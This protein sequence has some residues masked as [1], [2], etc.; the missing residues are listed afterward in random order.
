M[1][2]LLTGGC[3][4]LGRSIRRVGAGDHEFVVFDVAE[5]AAAEGGVC[6]SITD[7]A[8]VY[9]AAEGCDA[10]IHTAAM[11]GTSLGTQSNAEFIRTNVIGAE[12]L[13]QAALKFDIRR[14]VMSSTLEVLCGRDWQ[15][16]GTAVYDEAL[17]PRPDWIY[18]LTKVQV[19]QLGSFYA[20]EYGLE[21]AQLR[22]SYVQDEPLEVLG[23]HLLARNVM[24]TDAARANL[25][26]ATVAGLR[27]EVF[28][29]ACDT[30]LTQRDVNDARVDPWVVLERHWP[31]C[32]PVLEQH[33]RTPRY[34]HFWPVSRIDKAKLMLGWQP[35]SRFDNYLRHLGWSP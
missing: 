27:E 11:H 31:G 23:M 24:A 10:I 32:R 18:P 19:E 13:F 5:E 22:Y 8:A 26:A 14:L 16:Y 1:R 20:R 2:I 12:H 15:A 4:M 34:E 3:G 17:P 29:I 25:L 21:V 9:G 35:E 6:G 7:E 28:L 30:P 33:G